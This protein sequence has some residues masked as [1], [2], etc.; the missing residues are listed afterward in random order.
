M[1]DY[2]LLY[3]DIRGRAECARLILNYAK[4][5]FEDVRIPK[6]E[7][8]NI[9]GDKTRFPYG[10]VP[11][12]LVDN[13]PIAQS[14]ALVRYLA[15]EA[16]LAGKNNLEAAQIGQIEET[17]RIFSDSLGLYRKAL[18]MNTPNQETLFT[19]LFTPTCEKQLPVIEGHITSN[20]FFH[21]SGVSYVDFYFADLFKTFYN[22]HQNVMSKYPKL[23]EHMKKVFELPELQAYL[24]QRSDSKF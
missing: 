3:F 24:K 15:A 18:F 8:E 23:V 19:N 12:L 16:G 13:V 4:I 6:G 1:P 22:V 10:Q 9:K 20:G 7:W 14:M 5:P 2:K 17:C 11:V 21:E